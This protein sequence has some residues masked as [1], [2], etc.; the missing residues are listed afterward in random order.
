MAHIVLDKVKS[1]PPE[2]Y[3]S[4]GY[5]EK[6]SEFPGRRAQSRGQMVPCS[7]GVTIRTSVGR[8][9]GRGTWG[10]HLPHTL[11]HPDMGFEGHPLSMA[12]HREHCTRNQSEGERWLACALPGPEEAC[13]G[14]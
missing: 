11:S 14:P 4:L 9:A 13:S 8:M 7:K 12:H 1:L 6:E 5:I 2:I 10:L 3:V